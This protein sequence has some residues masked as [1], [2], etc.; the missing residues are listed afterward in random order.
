MAEG[1]KR[2]YKNKDFKKIILD[3][4]LESGSTFLTKNFVK[5]S[6]MKPEFEEEMMIEIKARSI[7]WSYLDSIEEDARNILESRELG[8]D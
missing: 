4:Y 3:G 7:A 6:K 1:L 8:V 2:L 5:V